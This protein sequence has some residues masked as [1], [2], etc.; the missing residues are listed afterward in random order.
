MTRID[1]ERLID[2]LTGA[3]TRPSGGTFLAHAAELYGL[4]A[5]PSTSTSLR[6]RSTTRRPSL[7]AFP[8]LSDAE[9]SEALWALGRFA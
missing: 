5:R 1:P 4:A 6:R 3:P 9:L 7:L 2:T 8:W